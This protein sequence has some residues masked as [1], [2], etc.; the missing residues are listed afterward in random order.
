MNMEKN[1]ALKLFRVLRHE[2]TG[3]PLS[4]AAVRK[5][6]G[7]TQVELDLAAE[8]L[9]AEGLIEIERTYSLIES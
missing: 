5:L 4:D 1:A 9:E 7:F 2:T 8:E 3:K 6:T